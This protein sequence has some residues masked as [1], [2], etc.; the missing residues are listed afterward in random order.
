VKKLYKYAIMLYIVGMYVTDVVSEGKNGKIYHSVLLRESFRVAN[1]V[2]SR[3]IANLSSLSSSAVAGIKN[4]LQGKSE[5]TLED[6]AKNSDALK[7]VQGESFGAVW[8]VHQ[9]AERIGICKALG[10]SQNATLALAQIY[11]RLLRPGVSILGSIR[12]LMTCAFCAICN[13]RQAFNEDDLYSNGEWLLRKQSCTERRLWE[14]SPHRK[15]NQ[16]F[17]YDVTSSYLEGDKNE[18]G[19]FGY[20][21]DKKANKKQLVIG[22]LTDSTGDPCSIKVYEGNTR[23]FKTFYDQVHNVKKEFKCEGITLV[24]D[25]GMIRSSQIEEAQAAGFTFISAITKPQIKKLIKVGAFQLGLFDTEFAEILYEGSRYILRRNPVR[26]QEMAES[27]AKMK[28]FLVKKI[29]KSNEYLNGHP[30]A[31]PETQLKKA[32]KQIEKFKFEAWLSVKIEGRTLILNEDS[33]ALKEES[34][35]DGC[36]VIRTDVKADKMTA[37]EAHDRYKDLAKV[38][39]D[40]RILKTGHME[41]RPWFVRRVD[42]TQAH[43]HVSMLGLKIRRYLD[44]AWKNLDIT[45]EEGLRELEKICVINLVEK[46]GGKTVDRI[47]PEPDPLQTKLL[48]ALEINL[49]KKIPETKIEVGTRKKIKPTT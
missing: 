15:D 23:D 21:R 42:N 30:R 25:R 28:D 2:C 4:A 11:S 12:F 6:L 20:N 18:L 33:Q 36:Y 27:R 3:T 7:L 49:P 10:V 16:L 44:N 19:A 34:K 37:K 45:V 47:L 46:E 39:E 41:F 13:V 1:K 32:V 22:L 14:A 43:A 38:E 9:I 48:E 29:Q 8:V 5:A 24:G 26:Q 40:F 31:K 35:L 17:L